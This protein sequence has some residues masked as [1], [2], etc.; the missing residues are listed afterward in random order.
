M[1]LV[2]FE[3]TIPEIALPQTYAFDRAAN[4]IGYY[5]LLPLRICSKRLHQNRQ[6]QNK[7]PLFEVTLA[8]QE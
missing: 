3:P 4:G 1:R 6:K 2:G 8:I 5:S 7:T